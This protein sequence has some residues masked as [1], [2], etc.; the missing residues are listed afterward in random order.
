SA[1]SDISVRTRWAAASMVASVEPSCWAFGR[2][3]TGAADRPTPWSAIRSIA[4][5]HTSRA[6][7]ASSFLTRRK[8]SSPW[9]RSQEDAC[10]EGPEDAARAELA[11]TADNGITRAVATPPVRKRDLTIGR[12]LVEGSV[13]T[14]KVRIM[15]I[16][17]PRSKDVRNSSERPGQDGRLVIG[18]HRV[19]RCRGPPAPGSHAPLPAERAGG[20]RP[21]TRQIDDP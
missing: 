12:P 4:S 18:T 8:A 20:P 11:A 2:Q 21:V 16:E 5:A 9:S 10:G 17:P 14:Q 19:H 6:R 1:F 15:R 7:A 3:V 13:I